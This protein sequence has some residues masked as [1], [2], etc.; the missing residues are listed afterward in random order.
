MLQKR[1]FQ[2][3][4]DHKM[5]AAA[6]PSHQFSAA[7][8]LNVLDRCDDPS[9]LLDATVSMVEP[10][11]I[12]L[13]ATVL[14][15]RALVHEGKIGSKWGTAHRR[16]PHKPLKLPDRSGPFSGTFEAKAVSFLEG[17]KRQQPRLALERWT[18]LPYVSTGDTIRTHFTLDIALMAFRVSGGTSSGESVQKNIVRAFD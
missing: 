3:A 10:G 8:L 7:A 4:V 6:M 16:K 1:G 18:R 15:F 11:G 17:I 9:A 12:V 5:A 2:T 13:L 14:P